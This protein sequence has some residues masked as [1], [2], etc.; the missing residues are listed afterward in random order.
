MKLRDFGLLLTLAAVWGASFLFIRMGA[1]VLRPFPLVTIRVLLAGIALLIYA[2]I[3][4][5]QV[6][7]RARWQHYLML[8]LLNNALPYVLIATAQLNLTAS[9]ASMLNAT[10]P[11]FSAV[12]AALWLK[13]KLSGKKIL[14][15]VLGLVGVAIIVGWR[16][17]PLDSV[18]ILSI[19]ASLGAAGSY[20][21]ASVYAKQYFK[22]V[23][24][25]SVAIG[26]L[27]SAGLFTLPLAVLNPPVAMPSLTIVLAMIGLAL[28]S[29]AFAYLLYFRLIATAGPTAAASVTFLIP[30]FSSLWG[31]IFLQEGIDPSEIV[32]FG[33]IL[34]GL[35][36]VLGLQV[37]IPGNT[38]A[39]Q[40]EH[41]TAR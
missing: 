37:R 16:P 18:S 4:A 32:G 6:D 8:G 21:V 33:V 34:M 28:V 10:T 19:G 38:L 15:L 26:Q 9:L 20:G 29:T 31:F 3:V 13:D 41:S 23:P 25:L 14:G 17:T 30:F 2:V 1:P 27:F 11:L 22:G 7:W 35:V 36:L 24:V 39:G 40:S 12:V 5:H